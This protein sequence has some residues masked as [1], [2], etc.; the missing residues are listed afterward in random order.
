MYVVFFKV[1]VIRL[2]EEE[3]VN[4]IIWKGWL[5]KI[6]RKSKKKLL[7]KVKMINICGG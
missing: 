2:I 5:K 7:E 4:L 3:K 6:I 1:S